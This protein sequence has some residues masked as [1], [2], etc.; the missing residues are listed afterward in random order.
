MTYHD[1]I[2]QL[3]YLRQT[4]SQNKKPLGFFLAAGCPLAVKMP[5]GNS[6]LIPDIAGLTKFVSDELKDKVGEKNSFD[7]L[8]EELIKTRKNDHVID[9]STADKPNIEDILSFVRALKQVS[10]GAMDVRG[11]K[12]SDLTD[13][14]KNICE[15]IVAKT[16]V[17]LPDKETPYH[18]LAQWIHLIDRGDSP[19]ECFTTNYDLLAEQ[20]FE[21]TGVAY[22]DGF[23][24]A[25][26]PF[27]DLRAIEDSLIPKHWTRLWKVHGSINWYFNS[28]HE[29]YRSTEIK[30]DDSCIIDPSHLKYDQS[31]KMPYLALID[32]LSSFLR[33]KS[34]ILITNG[35]SFG[36]THLNDT[37]INALTANPTA[38]VIALLHDKYS[39]KYEKAF[40]YAKNRYN[41]SAWTFDEAVIGGQQGKWKVIKPESLADENLGDAIVPIPETVKDADGKDVIIYHHQLEL[42]NFAKLGDFLQALIGENQ[43]KLEKEDD[44]K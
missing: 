14:E 5:A 9:K 43:F 31:R 1:P 37:I 10:G 30:A 20:A 32:R 19:I 15:K 26:Q 8:I 17:S 36:D 6:P 24:G 35:Y 28:N 25:R 40:S 39:R 12:E 44:A 4:L 13:L 2:R 42:G 22:F 41:L 29:I 7:I 33:Q 18:Q 21:E 3:K 38:M 11:L 23:V 27:F 16:N 34:A